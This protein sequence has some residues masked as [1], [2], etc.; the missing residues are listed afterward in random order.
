MFTLRTE[1]ERKLGDDETNYTHSIQK[2]HVYNDKCMNEHTALY[3]A[4]SKNKHHV[5]RGGAAMIF[6]RKTNTIKLLFYKSHT[7]TGQSFWK[8]RAYH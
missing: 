6:A 4:T 1:C 3:S 5:A 2:K 8:S 7:G